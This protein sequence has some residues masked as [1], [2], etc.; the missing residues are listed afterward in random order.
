MHRLFP[1][2][3]A[4]FAAEEIIAAGDSSTHEEAAEESFGGHFSLQDHPR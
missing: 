2:Q 3:I 1:V 4:A